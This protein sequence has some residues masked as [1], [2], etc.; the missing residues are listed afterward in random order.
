MQ[1]W[2]GGGRLRLSGNRRERGVKTEQQISEHKETRLYR[3]G[4]ES[5]ELSGRFD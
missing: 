2:Q 3:G 5:G 1:E 4:N